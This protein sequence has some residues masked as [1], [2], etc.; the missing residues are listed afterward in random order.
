[1]TGAETAR[2]DTPRTPD[3]PTRMRAAVLEEPR[4]FRSRDVA[5]PAPGRGEVGLRL[6]GCGVCGS[7]LPLW[8][9]RPWFDYPRPPGLPGHEGW[10][11]VEAVGPEVSALREG[12]RVASLGS[13]AFASYQVVPA[14][15]AVPLPDAL[16]GRPFPG[17]PLACAVNVARRAR[18]REGDRVAVIGIGFLGALLVELAA[19]AGA[20]VIALSRRTTALEVARARGAETTVRLA[21][22]DAEALERVRERTDG[23]LCDRVIE[24]VGLQR[25]LDLASALTGVRGRL[26]IA[27]YHQDG[28]RRVDVRL[29][30]WRGIDVVNAHERD[31]ATYAAGVR[32]AIDLVLEGTLDPFPLLTHDVPLRAVDRAF[33]LMED[34]PPGFLKAVVRP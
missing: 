8:Q 14:D 12:D 10:G 27:G 34:R 33:E 15:A 13:G 16:D 2:V 17:E 1:M 21:E 7:D 26:V 30:N 29:W 4:R 3:A 5:R 18:I 11:H 9:G 24:A 19:R 28:P 6:E 20:R 23:R 25:T 32:R 31:R 22:D